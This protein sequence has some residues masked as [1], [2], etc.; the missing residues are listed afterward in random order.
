M[1]DEIVKQE[2]EEISPEQVHF[3]V[4]FARELEKGL[5][6][7]IYTPDLVNS[8]M[9]DI[10]YNP[11]APLQQQLDDAL[12]SP[13][14]NED[15]LR[16]FGQSFE[17][18]SQTYKRLISYLGNLLSSHP[19]FRHPTRRADF[20]HGADCQVARDSG[21]RWRRESAQE[22]SRRCDGNH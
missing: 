3:M 21:G 16:N 20:A 10:S 15:N 17:I 8:R 12:K 11:I 18:Q 14:T 4:E 1:T 7:G 9:R 2:P 19:R 6:P 22:M 13:K 5:F